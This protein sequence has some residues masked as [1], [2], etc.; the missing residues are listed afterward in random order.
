MSDLMQRGAAGRALTLAARALLRVA[1]V[2][3][4]A[5]VVGAIALLMVLPRATHGS[6]LTVLTGS[7]RPQIPVGSVVLVRPVDP[8]TLQVGDVATYQRKPGVASYVTHRIAEI[9]SS[10]RP[11]TFVFKGDANRGA[12]IDPVPATAIRGAVWFHVPYV[13]AVRDALH[14]KAGLTLIAI[15]VLGGYALSQVAGA[16]RDRKA[17]ARSDRTVVVLVELRS[18]EQLDAAVEALRALDPL[19]VELADGTPLTLA[20]EAV[21]RHAIA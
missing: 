8:E 15:L 14:G 4:L 9:D 5:A 17:P 20:P 18:P 19:R 2:V 21:P 11:T 7:M 10:T 1:L 13:G 6:A 3:V 16:I 12:D